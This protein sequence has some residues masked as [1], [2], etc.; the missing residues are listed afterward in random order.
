MNAINAVKGFLTDRYGD[1]I[2]GFDSLKIESSAKFPSWIAVNED[3]SKGD[4]NS[5]NA[6]LLDPEIGIALFFLRYIGGETNVRAQMSRA[7]SYRSQLLPKRL[8]E[9]KSD[10]N[11]SWR[12]VI[13]WLVDESGE[14]E[15]QEQVSVLRRDTSY[16]EELPVDAI[17]CNTAG[18][19]DSSILKHDLPRLLL[20]T[21]KVLKMQSPDSVFEW[22]S[23]DAKVTRAM[24][25][26][27]DLFTDDLEHRLANKVEDRLDKARKK[28]KPEEASVS[29]IA[30]ALKELKIKDFRNIKEVSLCFS[31]DRA[32][33]IVVHGPNG[34]GK[35]NLFEA[36][37]FAL[38]GTSQRAQDFVN[39]PDITT[40][41]K[42]S[43]YV[44]GYL[45]PFGSG[46]ALPEI[47]L[48]KEKIP[49]N[50][51]NFERTKLSGNLLVQED[52]IKFANIKAKELSAEILGEFSG[53][54]DEIRDYAED[55]YS[56]A[57]SNLKNMLARLGLDRAGMISKPETA[58]RKVAEVKLRD[59]VS[60]PSHLLA[61]LQHEDW[62]WSPQ[63]KQA[64]N[65]ANELQVE[66]D[67]LSRFSEKLGKLKS[68]E[69]LPEVIRSFL[70]PVCQSR[71][72]ADQF[73]ASLGQHKVNF[74]EDMADKI[75]VWSRW[76]S[77]KQKKQVDINNEEISKKTSLRQKFIEEM[78]VL[79][80]QGQLFRDREHH[81]ELM[82]QFLR[83]SW[84]SVGE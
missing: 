20:K 31:E 1:L 14:F 78:E 40:T 55:E 66:G 34:S 71:R 17:V 82:E 15:W 50:V 10:S 30:K 62:N 32:Q 24:A 22:S 51:D 65:I 45:T 28:E 9:E 5:Q 64:I 81:F 7:I 39:D 18:N 36:L 48:N 19:W 74:I 69:M 57:Q 37:E 68:S 41:K 49:I 42:Y 35:S 26:F 77:D 60:L 47:N 6:L 75:K 4:L 72:S 16:L 46:G 61:L 3:L 79:T 53:I 56:L 11:G 38:R 59:V 27:A 58:R 52:T 21:R 33:S 29:G 83:G 67:S 8:S 25:G 84:E 54:A 12:V 63:T 44:N 70:K 76:L 2:S 13:H 80:R 43:E 23:A 73:L